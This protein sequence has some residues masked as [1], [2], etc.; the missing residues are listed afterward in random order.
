MN[1]LAHMQ[2]W[3]SSAAEGAPLISP[4]GVDRPDCASSC[5]LAAESVRDVLL[6]PPPTMAVRG[7]LPAVR[8]PVFMV[9][10][11]AVQAVAALRPMS[12]SML[13]LG[14]S[15]SG[16][17]RPPAD[18]GLAPAPKVSGERGDGCRCAAAGA[19]VPLGTRDGVSGGEARGDGSARPRFG[20]PAGCGLM[21]CSPASVAAAGMP[22][23]SALRPRSR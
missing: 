22:P 16:D 20:D 6:P 13:W 7:L 21:R 4:S 1:K 18:R 23:F 10:R 12:D 9:S 14:D 8:R 19:Y 11:A 17:M 3:R 2:T 15:D 5:P